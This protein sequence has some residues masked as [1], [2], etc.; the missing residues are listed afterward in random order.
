MGAALVK[1]A[2]CGYRNRVPA[3]AEGVPRGGRCHQPLFW[4]GDVGDATFAEVAEAASIPVVVDTGFPGA[5]R[6]GW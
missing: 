3:A 4:I 5:G 1:Y 6:A 2:N